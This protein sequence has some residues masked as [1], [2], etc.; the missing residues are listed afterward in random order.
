MEVSALILADLLRTG[1][2]A[3]VLYR[4]TDPQARVDASH[5]VSTLRRVS[6]DRHTKRA[7]SKALRDCFHWRAETVTLYRDGPQDFMFTT[8]SGCPAL[9]GLVPHHGT[10]STP[11]G[12]RERVYYGVHT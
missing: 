4:P 3:R 2:P 12:R 1:E 10:V 8:S 6:T 7:L 11:V 5:A 9:G